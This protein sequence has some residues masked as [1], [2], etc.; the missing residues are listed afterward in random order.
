MEEFIK[1]NQFKKII[2]VYSGKG[3]VGKST[4]CI[5]LAFSLSNLGYRVGVFDAD[6]STPSL[7]NMVRKVNFTKAIME[8]IVVVPSQYERISLTSTGLLG[9]ASDGTFLSGLYLKGAL[10]Q[11]IFGID[12]DVDVL[13]IDMPPG[14][15][16]LHKEL[17]YFLKGQVL[18]VTTPLL[19]PTQQVMKI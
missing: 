4:V 11:L 10:Y 14:T 19:P 18:L 12:W 6:L 8:D 1:K 9:I 2:Y 13:L 7:P 3:G 15:T 5:N 17:F 16:D